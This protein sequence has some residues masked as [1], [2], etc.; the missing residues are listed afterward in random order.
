ML[1]F[2]LTSFFLQNGTNFFVSC[3]KTISFDKIRVP[4][5]ASE[6]LC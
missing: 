4:V 6:G 1:N 3:N 5:W 2:V